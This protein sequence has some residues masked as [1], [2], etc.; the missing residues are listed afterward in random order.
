MR[1]EN[2][3]P[4]STLIALDALSCLSSENQVTLGMYN[5]M[6]K[7]K[8]FEEFLLRG[9]AVTFEAE[10]LGLIVCSAFV[11]LKRGDGKFLSSRRVANGIFL[12]YAN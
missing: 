12:S 9:D 2:S 10:A 6:Q 8:N 4:V 3:T 5:E 11:T 7:L 1:L